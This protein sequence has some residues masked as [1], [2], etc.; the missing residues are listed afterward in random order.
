M[1]L[2]QPESGLIVWMVL[3]FG[4]V[5]F[6]LVEYGFPAIPGVVVKKRGS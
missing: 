5:F 3:A 6:L 2:L 1:G 4:V